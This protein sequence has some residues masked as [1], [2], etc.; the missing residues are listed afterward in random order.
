[1]DPNT[2]TRTHDVSMP[3][4]E[5]I[6]KHKG[7]LCPTEAY[8]PREYSC[9]PRTV[10]L[11]VPVRKGFRSW[12]EPERASLSNPKQSQW[13]WRTVWVHRRHVARAPWPFRRRVSTNRRTTGVEEAEG[14]SPFPWLVL[15][16]WMDRYG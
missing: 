10:S 9:S 12:F 8:P 4:V 13:R 7:S 6:R 11:L 15:V 1:M 16:R 2:Q 14:G 5:N 3:A